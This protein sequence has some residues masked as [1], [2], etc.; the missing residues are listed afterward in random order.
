VPDWVHFVVIKVSEGTLG[1]DPMRKFNMDGAVSRN[2]PWGAYHFFR[3]SQDPE[4]QADR[5]WQ[6]V[7]DVMP[8]FVALD[9]ESIADGLQPRDAVIKALRCATAIEQRFGRPPLLYGY[10]WFDGHILGSALAATPDIARCPL[11]M[12]DYSGGES[13]PDG[14][15]P[16]IPKPWTSW[17]MAQTSGNNSSHVPGIVGAVDHDVYNG[18]DHRF[19]VEVCGLPDQDA[20]S[21]EPEL[22]VPPSVDFPPRDPPTEE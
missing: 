20:V 9:F 10:P 12:A 17:C 7:G 14:W 1:L 8:A 2:I 3:S 6:A 11:W 22:S 15:H 21:T 4:G 19:R 13:P 18:D 5:L 16:F